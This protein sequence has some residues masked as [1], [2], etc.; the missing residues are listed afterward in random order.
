MYL[1]LAS[2]FELLEIIANKKC[3]DNKNGESFKLGSLN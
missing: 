3:M 2:N 1:V